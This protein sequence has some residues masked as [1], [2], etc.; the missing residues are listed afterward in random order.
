MTF[1]RAVST[2]S[3]ELE[4]NRWLGITSSSKSWLWFICM[5]VI[6]GCLGYIIY[7]LSRKKG[8]KGKGDD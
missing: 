5:V 6:G 8:R 7:R 3:G 4:F 1:P 2:L